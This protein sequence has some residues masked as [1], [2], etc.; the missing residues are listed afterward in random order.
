[1]EQPIYLKIDKKIQTL[2]DSEAFIYMVIVY[3]KIQKKEINRQYLANALGVTNKEYISEIITEIEKAGLLKRANYLKHSYKEGWIDVKLDWELTYENYYQV[4]VNFVRDASIPSKMKGFILRYRSLAFDDT[5]V[6]S[7]NRSDIGKKLK[8]SQPTLRK[9][10]A[11]INEMNLF[12]YFSTQVVEK[13][14]LTNEHIKVLNTLA[15]DCEDSAI[16][17]QCVWYLEKNLQKHPRCVDLFHKAVAG[18]LF[19][20]HK[21]GEETVKKEETVK[22]YPI[23]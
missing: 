15:T 1:M 12:E 17:K 6:V 4:S 19:K 22:I 20:K 14:T 18:V 23:T 13:Q 9:N 5:L 11:L 2:N 16:K 8:I 10:L 3:G 7:Y 21:K